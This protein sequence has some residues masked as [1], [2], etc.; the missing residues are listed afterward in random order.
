MLENPSCKYATVFHIDITWFGFGYSV[1]PQNLFL[2]QL[3][4]PC[5]VFFW[6]LLLYLGFFH[7]GV[8]FKQCI[9]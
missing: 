8:K 4:S 7:L 2:L 5:S 3:I 1:L 6:T 9:L